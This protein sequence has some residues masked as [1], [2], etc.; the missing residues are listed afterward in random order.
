MQVVSTVDSIASAYKE[1]YGKQPSERAIRFIA[2]ITRNG[3]KLTTLGQQHTEESNTEKETIDFQQLV[4][5]IDDP[6]TT[7]NIAEYYAL[8]YM[9]GCATE[10]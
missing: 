8:C 10:G 4:T 2:A 1:Q 6:E 3:E 5:G 9:K 7:C